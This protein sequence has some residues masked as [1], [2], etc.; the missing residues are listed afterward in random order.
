LARAAGWIAF[1]EPQA[2]HASHFSISENF[3]PVDFLSLVSQALFESYPQSDTLAAVSQRA[4]V[5]ISEALDEL[6]GKLNSMIIALPS[7]F[8]WPVIEACSPGMAVWLKDDAHI[9]P[10]S[11]ANTV[12]VTQSNIRPRLIPIQLDQLYCNILSALSRAVTAG[13]IAATSETLDN[14][15]QLFAPRLSRSQSAEVVKAFPNFYTSNFSKVDSAQMSEHVRQFLYDFIS[16]VPGIIAVPGL[17][18]VETLSQ[19]CS[20]A[21]LLF[22]LGS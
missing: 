19:V 21:M 12:S 1:V 16:A 9:V 2:H 4:N 6:L 7:E 20:W 8:V 13:H 11:T 17:V 14:T 18:V 15:I 22:R 3:V 10:E 5:P